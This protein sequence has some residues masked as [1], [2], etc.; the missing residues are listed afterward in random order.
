MEKT[1]SIR[2]KKKPVPVSLCPPQVSQGLA[3]YRIRVSAGS[4]ES[5]CMVEEQKK[6]EVKG[7]VRDVLIWGGGG[8]ES[9]NFQQIPMFLLAI[10]TT[11]LTS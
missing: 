10:V 1:T 7:N 9:R 4:L 5:S 3:R 11:T 6:G 8:D 2:R